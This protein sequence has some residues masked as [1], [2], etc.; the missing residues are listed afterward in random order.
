VITVLPAG[1]GVG[2]SG[3]VVLTEVDTC[4]DSEPPQCLTP[5]SDT[6]QV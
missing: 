5:G 6:G 4:H 2:W 3:V 1:H